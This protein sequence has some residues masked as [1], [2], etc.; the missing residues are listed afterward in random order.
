MSDRRLIC[1]VAAHTRWA[2][3]DDRSAA[4]SAARAAFANRFEQQVDPEGRLAPSERRKRAESA[5]RAYYSD[6]ARKSAAA[7]RRKRTAA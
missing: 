4:T 1:Q 2:N 6:L 3:E 7:R 5:K